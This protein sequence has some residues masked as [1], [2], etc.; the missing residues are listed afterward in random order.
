MGLNTLLVKEEYKEAK[1]IIDDT[2]GELCANNYVQ[3]GN[4]MLDNLTNCKIAC[5]KEKQIPVEVEM[6]IPV[7]DRFESMPIVIT[8]GNLLDNAIEACEKVSK[9]N[10]YIKIRMIQKDSRIFVEI[11][12]SFSGEIKIDKR[13]NLIT[14][15][16]C[17]DF[18]GYGISSIKKALGNMGDF[19]Y[20]VEGEKFCATVILY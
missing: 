12:N 3:T 1:R 2:L 13:G 19:I 11:E 9:E 5:A 14:T 16:K 8:V 18:H 7:E 4:V 20:R 6:R 17:S 15:K 10:R